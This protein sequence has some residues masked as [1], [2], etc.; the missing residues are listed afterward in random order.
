MQGKARQHLAGLAV[1]DINALVARA[2]PLRLERRDDVAKV[3]FELLLRPEGEPADIRMQTVRAD[4]KVKERAPACPNCA[5]TS[6]GRSPRPIISS[7]NRTSVRP[8]IVSNSSRARSARASVTNH[9]PVSSRKT[10]VPNPVMRSPRAS[11][12]RISRML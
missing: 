9:P 2:I 8:L 4:D 11:T 10:R 3:L 6:S 1:K 12:I 5:H 7:P